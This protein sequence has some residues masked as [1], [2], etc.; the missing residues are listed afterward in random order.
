MTQ[1]ENAP[2]V[3]GD[4]D[5]NEVEFLHTS[6]KKWYTASSFQSGKHIFKRIFGY[7]AVSR[8][9]V[10]FILGG[11]CDKNKDWSIVTIFEDD[12]WKTHGQMAHGRINFG[13]VPYGTDVMLIGGMFQD[14]QW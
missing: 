8:P 3:V 13:T 4:Y 2:F 14:N 7:G 12:Q 1:Y 5:N 11:C 9:G 10:V 6:H